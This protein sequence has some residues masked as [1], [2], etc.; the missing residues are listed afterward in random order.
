MRLGDHV[1]HRRKMRNT[2][3]IFVGK[4]EGIYVDGRIIL[5]WMLKEYGL[6]RFACCIHLAQSRKR[7]GIF[8]R[9]VI[10]LQVP[11]R[12]GI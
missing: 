9:N 12:L 2:Y 8:V 7:G 1:G 10:N 11:K 3:K 6:V 5:K 4:P